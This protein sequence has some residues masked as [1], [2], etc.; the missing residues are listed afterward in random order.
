MTM[1][2]MQ[3]SRQGAMELVSHEAIVLTRYL[4]S[5]G[6]WTIGIGHTKKAG[7][8]DPQNSAGAMTVKDVYDLFVKD[9]QSYVNDVN[10]A[11]TV[12]LAQNEFDALVSFHF[13]TGAIG[14]ATL[15][16][17]LNAGDKK[18]AA[19]Q[20]MDWSKPASIIPRRKQ[21]QALFADGTYSGGGKASVYPADANG[22]ID[23]GKGK[24]VDL[25]GLIP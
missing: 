22:K 6:V 25:A 11:V 15:T 4:D 20:F 7:P 10:G 12:A 21:E 2:N 8:P 19:A 9:L 13:N 17:T 3:L 24:I 14:T 18:T 5:V 23:W 16:R 1:A